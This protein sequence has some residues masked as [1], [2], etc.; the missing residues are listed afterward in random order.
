M[1]D[2]KRK[3][4]AFVLVA[5]S[6]YGQQTIV[7]RPPTP[8]PQQQ[9][10]PPQPNYALYGSLSRQRVVYNNIQ[11]QDSERQLREYRRFRQ[12]VNRH[13]VYREPQAVVYERQPI[14]VRVRH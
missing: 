2:L 9:T 5:G 4:A 7:V 10:L 11:Q 6:V 3:F 1:L 12:E 13:I 14:T 8:P